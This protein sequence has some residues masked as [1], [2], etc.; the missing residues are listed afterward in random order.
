[1]PVGSLAAGALAEVI[2]IRRTLFI[3]AMGY[4]L[5]NL[6]LVFSPIRHLRELP[7]ATRTV[8]AGEGA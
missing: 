6:W 7:E 8:A 4:L 2:G 5:S 1:M 3:G